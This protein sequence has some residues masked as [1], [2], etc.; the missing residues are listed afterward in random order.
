MSSGAAVRLI[1]RQRR[2]RA[3]LPW[4]FDGELPALNLGTADGDACD[5]AITA[6][7]GGALAGQ[8]RYTQV[9]NGR[10]KGGYITRHYGR[11]GDGLHAV[12]LEMCQRC[13][14]DESAD[15]AGAYD[16]ALAA[17]VAPVIEQ[18]LREML[19]WHP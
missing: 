16:E 18:L 9:V 7:L 13:Y 19:A 12:Q 17:Q 3:R 14:M 6:R 1:S 11:P 4:L 10:F 8:G 5:P 15:P 2:N